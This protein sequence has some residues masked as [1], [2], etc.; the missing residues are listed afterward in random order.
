[1]LM[2]RYFID[3]FR[4]AVLRAALAAVGALALFPGAASAVSITG[5]MEPN[6][7]LGP[8]PPDG[9]GLTLTIDDTI[10]RFEMTGPSDRWFAFAFDTTTMVGYALMVEG[11]GDER[12]VE[13]HDMSYGDPGPHL[14]PSSLNIVTL[15]SDVVNG[16]STVVV[17]RPSILGEPN[18]VD[19]LTSWTNLNVVWAYDSLNFGEP[20][21][22]HG[23]AGR[24]FGNVTFTVIPEPAT[25][26]ILL[27]GAVVWF[28]TDR[29]R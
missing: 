8:P 27:L 5:S 9:M 22:Y 6:L 23:S 20:P 24:G 21:D 12:S 17:E 19:F 13:E 16:L 15:I 25:W 28:M 11:H 3:R 29:R 18:R 1:M 4:A 10:T 14:E 26:I 2:C 7:L